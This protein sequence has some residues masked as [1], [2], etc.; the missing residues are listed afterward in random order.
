M[1]SWIGPIS[2][3]AAGLRPG[4][5]N[6]KGAVS[7][8]HHVHDVAGFGEIGRLLDGEKGR[9]GRGSAVRIFSCRA[10]VVGGGERRR[11]VAKQ[12]SKRKDR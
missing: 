12:S 5:G 11:H 7:A 2:D 8:V 10:H 3:I 9:S 6:N 4:V 1:L